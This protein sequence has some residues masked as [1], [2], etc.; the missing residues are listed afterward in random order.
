MAVA[1]SRPHHFWMSENFSDDLLRHVPSNAETLLFTRD[2][3]PHHPRGKCVCV[4]EIKLD[5]PPHKRGLKVP[6]IQANSP[7]KPGFEVLERG[8]GARTIFSVGFGRLK[9]DCVVEEK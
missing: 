5:G 7:G 6:R 3:S 4:C 9:A 2:H 1:F 8:L